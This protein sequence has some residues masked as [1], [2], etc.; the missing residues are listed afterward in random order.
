MATI[1]ASAA[2]IDAD[3]LGSL[4]G[5]FRGRIIDPDDAEYESAR[6]VYNGAVDRRPALITRP[7]DVADVITALR[8]GGDLGLT[9]AIRGG[10][11]HGA[12]FG[13]SEGGLVID[14][15]NLRGIRVEP[16]A[17]T[18]RVEP[19]CTLADV[20]HA[21]HPFGLAVP[22]G[23][24]GTTGIGGLT[25][26]GGVG[27][28]SR[29]AGLTIDNLLE[30]DVVLASGELVTASPESHADLFWAIRGGGG[31]F[32]IV[33][34]FLFRL[35]PA[36]TVVG[37]PMLYDLD[38][39]GEVLRWYRDFIGGARED[40][41]GWFAFITVPPIPAFPEELHLRKMAAIVWCFSGPPDE[42][43]G[44]FSPI[45]AASRPTLDGVQPMPFTALQTLF[46]PLFPAG[47]QWAWR[48][49]FVD[50]IP[51]PA[52]E[53]HLRFAAEMPT[54]FSTMHLYPIDG[55]VHRV[56]RSD[57][58]F[59]SR[60]SGWVQVIVG[61]DPDP[62]NGPAIRDWSTRYWEAM[63]PYSA[64]GAYVNMFME[65]GQER[66]R[67]AYGENYERLARTKARYD[68]ENVFHVNQNIRPA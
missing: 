60:G 59:N 2:P 41:S 30:A 63:H 35:H 22:T 5:S 17:G 25:L 8:F 28:L 4:R 26:G 64:G 67:T 33:T 13:T 55:A 65:E 7:A 42:A 39:A 16:A 44:V 47:L 14:L 32:G 34:S 45:R 46:D 43:D 18:V 68:P 51:D 9:I 50:H 3:A 56:G 10:G 24:F 66:V 54:I 57:T 62:A 36:S 27:Y 23:I 37:G 49:D 52:V 11:H 38:G 58:A 48:T 12:G 1:I 20:D 29:R 40:L 61:I 31:N 19:G 53:E 6:H 21:T 15:G